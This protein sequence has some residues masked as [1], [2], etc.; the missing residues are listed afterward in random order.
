[1]IPDHLSRRERTLFEELAAASDFDP[2]R[3]S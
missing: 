1:M 2:R 3:L